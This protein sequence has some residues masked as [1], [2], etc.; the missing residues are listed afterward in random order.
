MLAQD[1]D[2]LVEAEGAVQDAKY[3]KELLHDNPTALWV[4][5]EAH[6]AKAGVHEHL[7]ERAQHEAELKLAEKDADALK[8]FTALP[9]AVVYRWT[10]LREVARE[11]EV[12]DDLRRV[13]KDTDHVYANF[14]CAL[15]LYW[16][17][18]F[19]EA[20]RVLENRPRTYIDRLRPF[21]LAELDY[22]PDKQDWQARARRA[23]KE[24]EERCQD[25]AAVADAQSV[26]RLLGKK[27]DAVKASKALLEQPERFYTLRRQPILRCVSYNAGELSADKLLEGAGR[28]RWDQCLAHYNIAMTKLA[29]GDRDGAREHFDKAVETRA[30]GW[31]EYDM[32]WVFRARLKKDPNWPPWIPQGLAK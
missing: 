29:E 19:E 18:D 13:S 16:H 27:E 5:L 1:T 31:G 25:G 8:P 22:H 17:G 7:N 28:S 26:L 21:V 9:E 6:L 24:F 30:W 3:A 10:Y 12:L 15:T 20:L 23:L 2:D 14:C 11:G 32:S 4:S